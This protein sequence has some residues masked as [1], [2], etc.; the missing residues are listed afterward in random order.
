MN[1]QA[2]QT[3][4]RT[5]VLT[6]TPEQL[7]M[8]LYDG[9]LRFAEQGRLALEKKDYEGTYNSVSRCQ[10]IIT[11]MTC[12]LKHQVA[13]DLCKR[14]AALYNY[15]FRKLIEASTVHKIEA[16]EEAISLLKFQ[17]ETWAMLLDKLAREKAAT[18]ASK[19][20]MP[21]P[22]ERM[23]AMISMQG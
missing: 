8:M 12:S 17:R 7:Q 16:I 3:Y 14:L 18:H 6:A 21:E 2:A 5:R 23:E 22:S 1:P 15:I 13:P 4:L 20:D 19:L 9:A 10:K 11:E